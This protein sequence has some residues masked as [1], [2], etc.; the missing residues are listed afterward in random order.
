MIN[1]VFHK[2][3]ETYTGEVAEHSNLV[4]LAGIR[5]FPYPNLKYK[6]G[7]GRCGTCACKIISGA[8]HLESPNWKERKRL[9]DHLAEGYRLACQL[10]LTHDL[11]L[12]QDVD[13]IVPDP[14]AK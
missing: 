3:G 5:K 14:D 6:C 13:R 10:W 9:G 12:T 7:M 1:V 11:E 2:N 4:V 8:D